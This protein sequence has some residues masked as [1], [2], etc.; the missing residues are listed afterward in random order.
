MGRYYETKNDSPNDTALKSAI[1][2]IEYKAAK[3]IEHKVYLRYARLS[4]RIL[5]DLGQPDW[6]S[7]EV[8]KEGWKVI[9]K[10]PVK[11]RRTKNM[12]AIP[13]PVIGGSVDLLRSCIPSTDS[14]WQLILGFLL[15]AMKGRGPYFLMSAH[16]EMG[17]AKSTL[18]RII[19]RIVDPLNKGELSGLP[20]DEPALAVDGSSEYML[21]YDNVS[22]LSPWLSDAFCRVA[23]GGGL[24]NRKLYTDDEQSV[25]DFCSPVILNG[26]PDFTEANDLLRRS[27]L[28]RLPRIT[29]EERR[30]EA[31]VF[32]IFEQI[33]PLVFG[34][35]LDMLSRGLANLSN[36][37]FASLPSMADSCKWIV[38]CQG[39]TQFLDEYRRNIEEA[40][41]VGFEASPIAEIIVAFVTHKKGFWKGTASE[42]LSELTSG[43]FAQHFHDRVRQRGFPQT[44]KALSERLKRDAGVLRAKGVNCDRGSS[45]GDRWVSLSI[46]GKPD[47]GSNGGLRPGESITHP[48]IY[49]SSFDSDASDAPVTHEKRSC[50]TVKSLQNKV[51]TPVSDASDA[52][53]LLFSMKKKRE[54][55][56]N[57]VPPTPHLESGCNSASLASL[58]EG[59][60]LNSSG[61]PVTHD[62]I[63]C[64]TGASLC[65][66]CVTIETPT[67]DK[68]NFPL[69][70]DSDASDA[71]LSLFSIKDK[72]RGSDGGLR[73]SECESG[74]HQLPSLDRDDRDDCFPLFSI[75][76]KREGV[77]N[78]VP[79]PPH[80]ED[81]SKQ[82]SLSSLSS[83]NPC[84]QGDFATFYR[85][86][87]RGDYRDDHPSTRSATSETPT[88]DKLNLLNDEC[89]KP[90]PLPLASPLAKPLPCTTE[91][92]TITH[93]EHSKLCLT[94]LR[95]CVND[96]IT[97][98][99]C[100]AL[101]SA[102]PQPAP[103]PEQ[104]KV[105]PAPKPKPLTKKQQ[106]DLDRKAYHD[107]I[108]NTVDR[109]LLK[110]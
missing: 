42:L 50:V 36:T 34:A 99:E 64:V 82:S 95:R 85:D 59:N 94:Y 53:F 72:E 86:D 80:L 48:L 49:Q 96:E 30:E 33:R 5:I 29:D 83:L 60:A 28:V 103:K 43:I 20:R 63:L 52:D 65:G 24:K 81:R 68:L 38:A 37:M 90:K 54:G 101:V 88:D 67:D 98:E 74:T 35:L 10:P 93:E 3:G 19:R 32:E 108:A 91:P 4:D 8:S 16:G 57:G 104:P 27:L 40:S 76:E 11:F 9:T 47:G 26:I 46:D 105:I 14:T 15:D 2:I 31:E 55:V 17:S 22:H 100:N 110:V 92:P 66:S 75:K 70:F 73:P 13:L 41:E 89:V 61:L 87:C 102:L 107:S 97:V 12:G 44:A 106:R 109:I 56:D 45:N 71:D 21:S 1:G 6:N 84:F 39:S 25:L 51:E 23:T 7:V 18:C 69:S 62:D 78:G 58:S 77:N 79:H